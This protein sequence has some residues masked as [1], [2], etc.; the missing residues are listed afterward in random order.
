MHQ[1]TMKS[2]LPRNR[3]RSLGS[4]WHGLDLKKKFNLFLL[5]FLLPSVGA[6]SFLTYYSLKSLLIEESQTKAGMVLKEARAIRSYVREVLRPEMYEIVGQDGFVIQAMSTTFISVWIQ[7]RFGRDMPGY[8]YRRVATR[9]RNPQNSPDDLE[10]DM[11]RWFSDDRDLKIWSGQVTRAGEPVFF[12]AEPVIVTEECMKCHGDP[13]DSPQVMRDRYGN[14]G[15]FH[16]SVGEVMGLN[17]VSVPVSEALI[18]IRRATMVIAGVTVVGFL[19]LMIVTNQIFGRLVAHRLG[20]LMRLSERLVD[21]GASQADLSDAARGDEIEMLEEKMDYLARHVRTLRSSYG[22]GP[23]FVG[24]YVVEGP[25]FPGF[26]SWLYS[27]RHSQSGE[28]VSLKI[29][30][31]SLVE[32]PYYYHAFI[33]EL[34]ILE[35]ID[36]RNVIG[37]QRN[38]K[39]FLVMESIDG[40]TLKELIQEKRKLPVAELKPIFTQLCEVMGY[41]HNRGIVHHNLSMSNIVVTAEGVVK[42]IDFGLAWSRELVDPIAEAGAGIQGT[43]ET[44]APEQI[45]GVRGDDRSDIYALGG[46]LYTMLT[47]ELPFTSAASPERLGLRTLIS[48]TPP[49]V[50]DPSISARLEAVILRS[51]EADPDDRYQWVEDFCEELSE[52][53]KDDGNEQPGPRS[54]STSVV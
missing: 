3:V 16:Y 45:K 9:P 37:V 48:A 49:R 42:L 46:I 33:N 47:G 20:F 11:L 1:S 54:S 53:W 24:K 52:A 4:W 22:V 31:P 35:S 29:P 15:G 12:I 8:T 23:K 27:A 39:D 25:K 41:L 21:G 50:H 5:L 18:K 19:V 32:N 44:I 36:H 38:G 17:S 26:V 2:S 43:V 7:K 30:F 28:Q 14:Q 51:L 13:K 34:Q 6:I 40:R 10:K